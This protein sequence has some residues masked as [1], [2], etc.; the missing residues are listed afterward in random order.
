MTRERTT[1]ATHFTAV[2]ISGL[3]QNRMLF[4][5]KIFDRYRHIPLFKNLLDEEQ[6][7]EDIDT[8]YDLELIK[9]SNIPLF[10][11]M[12][13]YLYVKR[14]ESEKKLVSNWL[15]NLDILV[16]E[17]V[18]VLLSDKDESKVFKLTQAQA[19]AF[20]KRRN[21]FKLE[22]IN[23]LYHFSLH[24]LID[25]LNLF[26]YSQLQILVINFFK[27]KEPTPTITRILLE[28]ENPQSNNE[29]FSRQL[30]GSGLFTIISI[31]NRV[32]KYDFPHRR[33]KEILAL[34]A[35]KEAD[36]IQLLQDNIANKNLSEFIALAF[37][38]YVEYQST[39]LSAL[40]KLLE[41]N[42]NTLYINGLI[43]NCLRNAQVTG[44]INQTFED[45]ILKLLTDN[46]YA[47][48]D[49]NVVVKISLSPT[50]YFKIF[51]VAKDS[52]NEYTISLFLSLTRLLFFEYLKEYLNSK[53]ISVY[54]KYNFK[55]WGVILKF[56]YLE[57]ISARS[58][59]INKII[60]LVGKNEAYLEDSYISLGLSYKLT[61]KKN[62][63]GSEDLIVDILASIASNKF[64]SKY[65]LEDKIEKIVKALNILNLFIYL[66]FLKKFNND[67]FQSY[68]RL[69]ENYH[70][71][72]LHGYLYSQK[73]FNVFMNSTVIENLRSENLTIT[74]KIENA[75]EQKKSN[76][77]VD[78][79]VLFEKTKAINNKLLS[80]LSFLTMKKFHDL[81]DLV[82][83]IEKGKYDYFIEMIY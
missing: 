45:W 37:E 51:E 8:S 76:S 42:S 44:R 81:T 71:V 56:W 13:C 35:L 16:I 59:E 7:V 69:T 40:L 61:T 72:A 20:L 53:I 31:E 52:F 6:F 55:F 73:D 14:I 47:S 9:L 82:A 30:I 43:Q 64:Y 18:N 33:F 1:I 74:K 38:N 10:L 21:D 58:A 28:Y 36:N 17:C 29:N 27:S 77:D 79:T 12:M 19:N 22:K 32:Y 66:S 63:F 3:G 24:L 25:G 4:V 26:D 78:D 54:E 68:S 46:K 39:I 62:L 80:D 70:V 83:S 5:K 49:K 50:F 11:T 65:Q 57:F 41:G 75:R 2:K 48:I 23:F 34:E 60:F 67:K 15:N